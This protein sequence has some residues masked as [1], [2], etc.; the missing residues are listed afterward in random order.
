MSSRLPS[1]T[2]QVAAGLGRTNQ[3]F[4]PA[5]Q[6]EQNCCVPA[7]STYSYVF[8]PLVA[9]VVMGIFML[10]LRWAFRSGQ[11]LVAE[12]PKAGTADQYGLMVPIATADNFIEA[13]MQRQRLVAAGIRTN[14]VSTVDGPRLM[15]WR[16][17]QDRALDTLNR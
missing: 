3:P 11:S 5:R 9:L 2:A 14:L 1:G 4:V 17:D 12:E 16:K 13:E 15:V 6:R 7:W 8:G 10:F